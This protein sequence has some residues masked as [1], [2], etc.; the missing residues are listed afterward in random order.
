MQFEHLSWQD[1]ASG[2]EEALEQ[3]RSPVR[4]TTS[5]LRQAG[6]QEAAA[7]HSCIICLGEINNTAYVDGCFHAFC[8]NCIRR[9][10][11]RRPACPFCRRRF[12]RILHTVTGDDYQEYMVGSSRYRQTIPA[13]ERMRS[14]LPEHI[15]NKRYRT[16]SFEL[17]SN[18]ELCGSET[19]PYLLLFFLEVPHSPFFC[20]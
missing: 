7:D 2:G 14:S 20:K 11:A 6:W 19:L 8:F 1:M 3:S 15:Y 16:I 9:W 4:A 13:R 12:D 5:Q 10:A 17:L 18:S